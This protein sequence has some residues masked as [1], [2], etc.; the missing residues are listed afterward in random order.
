MFRKIGYIIL[1]G[2]FIVGCVGNTPTA[3]PTIPPPATMRPSET[4]TQ[5]STATN[6]IPQI[7]SP[8]VRPLVPDFTHIIVFFFENHEF[9]VVA[10]NRNMP[11]YNHYISENTLLT[12]YYAITHPSLPNYIATFG[13]DTFKITS[14]CSKCFVNAPSLPDQIEAS[15]R[16][17][18]AYLEDMP[19]PCYVGDTAT[20]AQKHN[21]F[22]YF[23]PIRLDQTRCERSIVPLTELDTDLAAGKLP[24]FVYI[25]PNICN[26]AHDEYINP[27][28]QRDYSGL[29][30]GK[31]DG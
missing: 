27:S 24:N 17:W 31:L 23:D 30:V 10:G 28:L 5:A 14:D 15:G 20:Y 19:K 22:I 9:D 16:T 2:L 8:T 6:T 3:Q 7:P 26:S 12:Q 25:M 1:W 21:P 13:G 11:N 4:P 18:R 29:V